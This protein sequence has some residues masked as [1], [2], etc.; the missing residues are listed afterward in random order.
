[1]QQIGTVMIFLQKELTN[2]IITFTS[3]NQSLEDVVKDRSRD[4]DQV[5]QPIYMGIILGY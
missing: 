5:I 3:F 2:T 1:M 4:N